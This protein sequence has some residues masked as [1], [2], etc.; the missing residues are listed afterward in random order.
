MATQTKNEPKSNQTQSDKVEKKFVEKPR[1]AFYRPKNDGKGWMATVEWN[2]ERQTFSLTLLP[3][4]QGD[5]P[6]Q[7]KFDAKA[8]L[9]A[10]LGPNDVGNFLGVLEGNLE[11]LGQKKGEYWS[12]LYHE[13]KDKNRVAIIGLS[14][15]QYGL[16]LSLSVK[17]NNQE[18]RGSV[19]L[20]VSDEK[21]LKYFLI[22]Y[23]NDMRF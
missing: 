2:P 18:R 6:E 23:L 1:R 14:R 11:G 22:K 8:A 13:V 19:S 20:A 17:E 9:F 16:I 15:G 12:G 21:I 10:Q 4:S 7:A 5:N 3:Q